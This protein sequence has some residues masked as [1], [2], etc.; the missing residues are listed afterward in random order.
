MESVTILFN[1]RPL[2]LPRLFLRVSDLASC[3]YV[4]EEGLHLKCIQSNGE[5]QNFFP[6]EGKFNL[7]PN[8]DE[9]VLIAVKKDDT[10]GQTM[11]YNHDIRTPTISYGRRGNAGLRAVPGFKRKSDM[12][13]PSLPF[14][15]K[16]KKEDSKSTKTKKISV[17]LSGIENSSQLTGQLTDQEPGPSRRRSKEPSKLEPYSF[18]EIP[19]CLEQINSEVNV[20]SIISEIRRQVGGMD[21]VITDKKGNP[22]RDMPNTRGKLGNKHGTNHFVKNLLRHNLGR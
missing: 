11:T 14:P 17:W 8:I 6:Q 18:Y 16:K 21:Y 15:L 10:E 1:N 20:R 3:F 5:S 7:N 19:I 12:S 4:Q 9:Y 2:Q 22:I 13:S